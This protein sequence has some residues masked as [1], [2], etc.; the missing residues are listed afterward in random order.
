[1]TGVNSHPPQLASAAATADEYDAL[2]DLWRA[3]AREFGAA[4]VRQLDEGCREWAAMNAN[5]AWEVRCYGMANLYATYARGLRNGA[6]FLS[7]P[8][9]IAQPVAGSGI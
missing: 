9:A 1:V 4:H 5:R 8:P 2:G 3:K 7:P 6:A